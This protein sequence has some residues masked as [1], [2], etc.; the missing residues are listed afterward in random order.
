[1]SDGR[2]N[3]SLSWQED[4][5][6]GDFCPSVKHDPSCAVPAAMVWLGTA[7]EAAHISLIG[8]LEFEKQMC[9]RRSRES[10]DVSHSPGELI[11]IGH[12]TKCKM[13][14][15]PRCETDRHARGR[16]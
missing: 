15:S 16:I 11:M 8:A 6:L 14:V 13:K 9:G 3:S 1:M 4:R 2:P 10:R 12:A 5:C 7:D